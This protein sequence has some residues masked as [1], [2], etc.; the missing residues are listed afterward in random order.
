VVTDGPTETPS[1][2][3]EVAV[4]AFDVT[5]TVS[6]L[7]ASWTITTADDTRARFISY[8]SFTASLGEAGGD[9]AIV[10]A[11][12]E[13]IAKLADAVAATTQ[14]AVVARSSVAQHN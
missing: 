12:A 11:K 10:T 8:G 1:L 13:T 3:L 4:D 9:A 5:Q 14:A 6:V 7:T 2:R